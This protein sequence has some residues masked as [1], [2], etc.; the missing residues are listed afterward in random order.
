MSFPTRSALRQFGNAKF[1]L[2]GRTEL[3]RHIKILTT[4]TMMVSP[5]LVPTPVPQ[6]LKG[7]I[8]QCSV[9][10]CAHVKHEGVVYNQSSTH[11]G[12]SLIMFYPQG[13]R[14]MSPVPGS[15]KYIYGSNGMLTFARAVKVQFR[16]QG[17]NLN[18]WTEPS[19]SVQFR[20]RFGTYLSGS[21]SGSGLLIFLRT[22]LNW[23]EPAWT[24]YLDCLCR[25]LSKS[26]II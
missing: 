23:F 17:S 26:L 6:D 20:F 13:C 15:I 2:I 5:Y 22:G 1:F 25:I 18:L 7:L 14:T 8:H 3:H 19:S 12:N 10:L 24:W 16:T 11:V 4:T 21:G 9:V